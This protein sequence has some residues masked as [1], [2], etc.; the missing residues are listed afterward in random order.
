VVGIKEPSKTKN[1]IGNE[2]KFKNLKEILVEEVQ[3]I[4]MMVEKK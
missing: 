2:V 3:S 1:Y 4:G